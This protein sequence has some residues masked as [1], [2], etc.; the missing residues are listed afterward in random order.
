MDDSSLPQSLL[1]KVLPLALNGPSRESGQSVP[2]ISLTGLPSGGQETHTKYTLPDMAG[3]QR[4]LDDPSTDIKDLHAQLTR[5]MG[6]MSMILMQEAAAKAPSFNRAQT[7]SRA[8]EALRALSTTLQERE[9]SLYK[10]RL[11]FDSPRLQAFI[12]AL[13]DLIEQVMKDCGFSPDQIN[14]FFLVLQSRLPTFED[15]QKKYVN[16]VSFNAAKHGSGIDRSDDAT[17]MSQKR[18]TIINH[19]IIDAETYIDMP[20]LPTYEDHA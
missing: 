4:M 7:G 14:N 19:D 17:L 13:W 18:A 11:D 9:K 2:T 8:V 20:P 6:I 1:S 10:D 3:F 16:S 15:K 5:M 12:D